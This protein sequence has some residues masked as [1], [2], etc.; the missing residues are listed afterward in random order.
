MS[1]A[2]F[3]LPRKSVIVLM[4]LSVAL[5]CLALR[6]QRLSAS[7]RTLAETESQKLELER[8]IAEVAAARDATR[9]ELHDQRRSLEE[10]QAAVAKAER[11]LA[12]VAPEARWA[13]PPANV[14]EWDND[15]PYVWLDKKI[16][17]TL[18]GSPFT[19]RAEI[20]DGV[21]ATLALDATVKQALNE[22]LSSLVKEYHALEVAHAERIDEPLPGIANDGPQVTV[23]V[24]PFPEEAER[25][26][27][28][29]KETLRQVLGQQRAGLVIEGAAGWLDL[30]FAA[31]DSE[32]QT[33]SV[34]RHPDGTYNLSTQT[35]NSWF[36]TGGFSELSDH[37]QEYLLPLFTEGLE[38]S[39]R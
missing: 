12:R 19:D 38:Q 28:Q 18:P 36:S 34:V 6:S 37:V 11:E 21:A 24:Q 13:N 22:K 15:S 8:R 23:R 33:I 35:G 30:Q 14:P 26:K 1:T 7:R 27:Q 17:A 20:R 25:L 9:Q 16:L 2:L 3:Q 29:F 31:S 39:A 5:T 32:P 4:T 10:T